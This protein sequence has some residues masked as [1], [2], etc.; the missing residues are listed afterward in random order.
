MVRVC[1]ARHRHTPHAARA[2]R[3]GLHIG[4][5]SEVAGRRSGSRI[6]FL[7][8]RLPS[9]PSTFPL[10][11]QPVFTG[12]ENAF[13]KIAKKLPRGD[14]EKQ[15][16]ALNKSRGGGE[17][18]R[19]GAGSP[20][21]H[22]SRARIWN[23]EGG[24]ET[25][26]SRSPVNPQ[27]SDFCRLNQ[28]HNLPRGRAGGWRR[29]GWMRTTSHN[30]RPRCCVVTLCG[31]IDVEMHGRA[32]NDGDEPAHGVVGC[33]IESSAEG[34]AAGSNEGVT[35]KATAAT[36][37]TSRELLSDQQRSNSGSSLAAAAGGEGGP[38]LIKMHGPRFSTEF[39]SHGVCQLQAVL[40]LSAVF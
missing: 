1:Q 9:V 2:V 24:N 11:P 37:T 35:G 31:D 25:R 12:L 38:V 39:C 22:G 19:R 18:S 4:T 29:R 15:A 7:G 14:L 30:S 27:F 28:F 40:T 36:T 13:G 5:C 23:Y 26:R 6:F 34:G 3:G 21:P 8:D 20:L 33:R 17:G 10:L 16:T 32:T